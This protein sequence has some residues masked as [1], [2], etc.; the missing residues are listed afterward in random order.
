LFTF[1][2]SDDGTYFNGTY[3]YGMENTIEGYEDS[4]NGTLTTTADAENPWSGSW[5]SELE[6]I[7]TLNQNGNT[8]NGTYER[9]DN[10]EFS[11]LEGTISEDGK[12]LTG[13]W[14]DSGLFTLTLPDDG[15]YF[16]G[17]FG[18][19]EMD[20]IEGFENNWNG[21]RAE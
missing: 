12:T 15:M 14:T 11:T 7:T 13:T 6:A 20:S 1:T 19:N 8:V 18:Y 9:P 3:G 2:L 21:V 16:N 17:T 4:W 5:I 10:T